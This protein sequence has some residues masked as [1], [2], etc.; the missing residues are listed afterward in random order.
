MSAALFST[1]PR[2]FPKAEPTNHG[3]VNP[4]TGEILIAIGGLHD[5]LVASGHWTGKPVIENVVAPAPVETPVETP[6]EAVTVTVNEVVA[7]AVATV[8]EVV[9][10]APVEA[11]V[12]EPV[13]PAR[14]AKAKK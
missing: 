1:K 8:D 12:E 5:T 11:P 2:W 3:W 6:V 14:K 4:D 9:P 7:A 13:K 10:E